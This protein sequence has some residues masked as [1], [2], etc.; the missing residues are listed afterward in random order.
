[1]TAVTVPG[2][3]REEARADAY[4]TLAGYA[5]ELRLPLP[6]RADAWFPPGTS[7]EEAR[8]VLDA[9]E[10]AWRDRGVTPERT[11]TAA[12]LAITVCFDGILAWQHAWLSGGTP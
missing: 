4:R 8:A 5:R 6:P 10:Q 3:T 12:K 1:M 9:E 2:L 11:D 7:R